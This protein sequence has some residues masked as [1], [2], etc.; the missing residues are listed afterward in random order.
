[1]KLK[2][3]RQLQED[4]KPSWRLCNGLDLF[5]WSLFYDTL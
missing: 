4:K 2:A 1:M 3:R 5:E